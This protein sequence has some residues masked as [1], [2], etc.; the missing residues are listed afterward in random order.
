MTSLLN[1]RA[2]GH[3]FRWQLDHH[4]L[5]QQLGS[6]W[7]GPGRADEPGTKGQVGDEDGETG[8]G[9]KGCTV[10]RQEGPR[11]AGRC[12][13]TASGTVPVLK[14][15]RSSLTPLTH[16]RSHMCQG[17]SP[18]DTVRG[19]RGHRRPNPGGLP[20]QLGGREEAGQRQLQVVCIP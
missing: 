9:Q 1:R 2:K 7:R 5:E 16:I 10:K 6:W 4:E 11:L 20:S 12:W 13:Y 19:A 8:D 17:V 3:P 18:A 15:T 14:A